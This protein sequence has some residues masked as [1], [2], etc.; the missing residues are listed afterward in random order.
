MKIWIPLK[1]KSI[2]VLYEHGL[3]KISRER[4]WQL[5]GYDTGLP[6]V[7]I[8]GVLDQRYESNRDFDR[9]LEICSQWDEED[10][11]SDDCIHINIVSRP[12]DID[13]E[14]DNR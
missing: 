4:M 12:E 7:Y 5:L 3:L 1:Y 14:T 10:G 13:D 9:L 6:R 2:R 8:N 11:D